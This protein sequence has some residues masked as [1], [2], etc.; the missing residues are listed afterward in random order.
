MSANTSPEKMN[1]ERNVGIDLLR[2]VSMLMVVSLHYLGKGNLLEKSGHGVD[3]Y[4]VAWLLES[5]SIAAVN[6]YVL[7]SGYLLC[8]KPFRS[9][10][11]VKLWLQTFVYSAGIL[12]V[13]MLPIPGGHYRPM[14]HE[15]LTAVFPITMTHYWFMTAYV[16]MVLFSPLLNLALWRL[17]R[18]QHLMVICLLLSLFSLPKSILPVRLEFDDLGYSGLWFL[19]VYV[20][21]AYLRRIRE[22]ESDEEAGAQKKAGRYLGIYLLFVA[23]MWLLTLALER[24]YEVTGHL[25]EIQGLP[26]EYNFLLNIGAAICLFLFFSH[27]QIRQKLLCRI[28]A[29]AAPYTLGVYLLH[30]HVLIRYEWPKWLFADRI[31]NAGTLIACWLLAIL[32]VFA[33]GILLDHLRELLFGCIGKT[34]G[35]QYLKGK[36][37]EADAR[38]E[39]RE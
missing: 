18:K 8:K 14:M 20:I 24:I 12:L 23:A 4:V 3:V 35:C 25:W 34:R 30:E 2:I 28:I 10:R 27:L 6:T 19:V 22:E 9:G 16:I 5:L 1:T 29:F 39:I 32:I 36:L 21:A 13:M 11:I 37:A 17:D 7:I 26:M 38:L 33:A 15:L 31:G